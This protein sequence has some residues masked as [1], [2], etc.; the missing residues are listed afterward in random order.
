MIRVARFFEMAMTSHYLL[1]M[2]SARASLRD[3]LVT[4]FFPTTPVEEWEAARGAGIHFDELDE[5]TR[6]NLTLQSAASEESLLA[7][8]AMDALRAPAK[9]KRR[10][11][12]P[13]SPS[14]SH[15]IGNV[16]LTASSSAPPNF[17]PGPTSTT[18]V[19]IVT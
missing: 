17:R 8:P 16:T 4:T 18:A 2:L 15:G 1:V 14:A 3:R 5:L 7:R 11:G 6:N 9:R 10:A 12:L 19:T 13:T